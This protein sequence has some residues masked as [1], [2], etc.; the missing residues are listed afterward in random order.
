MDACFIFAHAP[1]S[2]AYN[3]VE[4]RMAPQQQES[5]IG[6]P[7]KTFGSHLNASNKTID[8]VLEEKNILKLISE[9]FNETKIV[10]SKFVSDVCEEVNDDL[11]EKWKSVHVL[12]SQYMRQIVKCLCCGPFR[13]NYAVFS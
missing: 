3:P 11:D 13:T 9:V 12:Q 1:G 4:R 8:S 2:I 5:G 7:F 6:L 10:V